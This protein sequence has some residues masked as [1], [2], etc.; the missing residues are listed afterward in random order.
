[1]TASELVQLVGPEVAMAISRAGEGS[2]VPSPRAIKWEIST[3]MA[4]DLFWR[5]FT[6]ADVQKAL[7]CSSGHARRL[8]RGWREQRARGI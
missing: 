3:R 7:G 2:I 4:Y 1:M 6:T 5:G 8:F